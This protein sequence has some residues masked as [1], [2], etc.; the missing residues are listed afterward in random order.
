MPHTTKG[1]KMSEKEF[2]EQQQADEALR[3][4]VSIAAIINELKPD[5]ICSHVLLPQMQIH[6]YETLLNAAR[7][8]EIAISGFA[9]ITSAYRVYR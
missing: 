3:A 2:A 1:A 9:D 6:A 5:E 8:L 7:T 4:I